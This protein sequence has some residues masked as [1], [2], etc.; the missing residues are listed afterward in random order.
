MQ[1]HPLLLFLVQGPG[2]HA[3]EDG[4][5]IARLIDGPIT[6]QT[7]GDCQGRPRLGSGKVAISLGAGRGL[8]PTE[9][10]VSGE[11]N[12]S[13]RRPIPSERFQRVRDLANHSQAV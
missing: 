9:P 11:V 13:T 2:P 10:G 12:W 1:V 6:V 4:Q 5:L 3:A 7:L 8:K